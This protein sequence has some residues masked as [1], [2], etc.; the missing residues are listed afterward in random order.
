MQADLVI[1][2]KGDVMLTCAG[3]FPADVT[4]VEY[5]RD[6]RL[7]VLMYDLPNSDGHM[8]EREVPENLDSQVRA[9][10]TVLVV[11]VENTDIQEGF[12]VPLVQIG[13]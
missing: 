4:R 10:A 3:N 2:Q 1:S 13:L 7:M 12:N 8:L 9:A 5:Y 11:R 6:T